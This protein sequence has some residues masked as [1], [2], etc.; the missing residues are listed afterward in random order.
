MYPFFRM[1]KELYVSRN[2]DPLPFTGTHVSHHRCW[3]WDLD[4]WLELNNGRTLTLF[5]LG[6]IPL[7][8]R[9]GLITALRKNGW[10]LTMAGV[11][12]RYRQRVRV[13]DKVEI[14]SRAV[15]WDDRFIYIDQTMWKRGECTSQALY[16]TAVTSKD[17]IVT[18]IR[19]MET[20]GD[21]V[22]SPAL[23]AWVKNWIDAD[24]T[25]PWPPERTAD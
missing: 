2:A 11:S 23:P 3:P 7:A 15:G 12:V 18:P 24:A 9:V 14:H 13:M 17:G 5:D 8:R 10:G 16:R 4:L 22:E 6:R 20:I 21:V 19:V 25:R 1:T